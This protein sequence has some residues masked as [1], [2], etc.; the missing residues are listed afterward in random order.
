[1]MYCCGSNDTDVYTN[2][3]YMQTVYLVLYFEIEL[4]R[5]SF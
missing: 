1:M 4:L 3:K 5:K 2:M